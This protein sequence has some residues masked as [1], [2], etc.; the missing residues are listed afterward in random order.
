MAGVRVWRVEDF[1]LRQKLPKAAVWPL[2]ARYG[3]TGLRPRRDEQR[4]RTDCADLVRA[5]QLLGRFLDR[6]HIYR[7]YSPARVER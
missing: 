5:S 4:D 6:S 7:P 2:Q 3:L 1:T